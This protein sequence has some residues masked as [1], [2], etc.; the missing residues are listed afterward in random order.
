MVGPAATLPE[1]RVETGELLAAPGAVGA[2]RIQQ[3]GGFRVK[4]N[5]QHVS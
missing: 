4:F 3:Q 2:I 5:L 1:I